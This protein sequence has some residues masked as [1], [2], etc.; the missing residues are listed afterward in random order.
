MKGPKLVAE[1]FRS[2]GTIFSELSIVET[3]ETIEGYFAI[4]V[5]DQY[6]HQLI[7]GQILYYQVEALTG[8]LLIHC[9]ITTHFCVEREHRKV[10][11]F[12]N[13][14]LV[15]WLVFL[16]DYVISN[17]LNEFLNPWISLGKICI[18]LL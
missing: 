10:L 7:D 2:S 17:S 5:E 4:R 13:L 12:T 11:F 1:Y 18:K 15:Q 8:G 14:K 16:C 3:I 9:R 6:W